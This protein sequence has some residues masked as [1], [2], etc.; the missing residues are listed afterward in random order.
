MYQYA[1]QNRHA[2]G[3]FR[4][5]Y[6]VLLIAAVLL[7]AAT[8]V[9]AVMTISGNSFKSR[10]RDAYTQA[11]TNNVSNAISVV[12]RMDSV[13]V[14]TTSQRLGVIRQYVYAMEQL[15]RISIQMFGEGQGRYVP[16]DAFTALY[17]DLDNYEMLVQSAKS[18]TVE[19]RELLITHLKLVQGYITGQLVS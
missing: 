13:T 1:A 19:T 6:K 7:L 10:S 14:S 8:V 15:N 3:N 11:M 4:L 18:S 2:T 16:D 12:N 9:L 5:R 17:Q